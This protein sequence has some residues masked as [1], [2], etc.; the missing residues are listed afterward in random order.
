M[1]EVTEPEPEPAA[2]AAVDVTGAS[3]EVTGASTPEAV[4]VTV[5]APEPEL[6]PEPDPVP[7]PVPTAAGTAEVTEPELVLV[8]DAADVTPEAVEVT[9]AVTEVTGEAAEVTG[10]AAEVL[11][12]D[13]VLA[14]A[15][16]PELEPVPELV[17]VPVAAAAELVFVPVTAEVTEPMADVTGPV[18]EVTGP[19]EAGGAVAACAC[20]ENTSKATM[21]PAATIATCTARR[22]MS[23]T[24]GCAMSS[25]RTTGGQIRPGS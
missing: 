20:R 10:A 1:A 25:S 19:A 24:I 3:T 5:P 17:L 21:I 18:A 22:A 16:V 15:E 6:G 2:E 4:P 11:V 8:P 9:E 12:L 13:T 14:A 23:R 7:V